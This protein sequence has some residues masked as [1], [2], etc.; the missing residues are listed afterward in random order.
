[1]PGLQVELVR[2]LPPVDRHAAV[3]HDV[4]G[5]AEPREMAEAARLHRFDV[6]GQ[7]RLITLD[8]PN[9]V[10]RRIAPVELLRHSARVACVPATPGVKEHGPRLD[11][12]YAGRDPPD[13]RHPPRWPHQ[14]C[15]TRARRPA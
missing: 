13:P 3:R 2:L 12:A 10:E 7:S 15:R 14:L 11:R 9:L 4:L 6:L 5:P 1:M 8:H